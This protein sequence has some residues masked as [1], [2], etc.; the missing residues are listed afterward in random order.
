MGAEENE[1]VNDSVEPHTLRRTRD[2]AVQHGGS[3]LT[4]SAPTQA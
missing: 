2:S 1:G 4:W 3:D